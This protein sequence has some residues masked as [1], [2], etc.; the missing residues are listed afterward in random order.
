M[1]FLLPVLLIALPLISYVV[2]YGYAC[3]AAIRTGQRS[4]GWR[5]VP[6]TWIA[7]GTLAS[8]VL[9]LIAIG[10]LEGAHDTAILERPAVQEEVEVMPDDAAD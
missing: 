8:A 1:R 5:E 4:P 3:R 10:F 6:W 2:W 7:I 9:A